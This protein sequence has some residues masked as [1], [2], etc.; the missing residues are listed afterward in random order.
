MQRVVFLG[1]GGAGKST[2]ARRLSEF[3]GL[4]VIELDKHFWP[5]DLTPMPKAE[6]ARVQGELAAAD[7]WIM[8]G[9][10]GPYDVLGVR[11]GRA[12]TVILLDFPF[13]TCAWRALR[14]SKERWDFWWWV[15]TWR[16]SSRPGLLRAIEAEAPQAELVVLRSPRALEEFLPNRGLLD[17]VHR[18][19]Q[20]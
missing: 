3:T 16:W 13:L 20:T 1:R 18:S 9:D 14:R 8:D 19:P 12:D 11:L 2:A 7:R 15:L 17:S 4:P 5:P 10:L 6:W